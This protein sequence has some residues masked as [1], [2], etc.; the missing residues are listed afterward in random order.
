MPLISLLRG[1]YRITNLLSDEGGFGRTYLAK[2]VDKLK[3]LCVVKQFAPKVQGSWAL[4]KA[5]TLFQEEAKR[6]Q[7]LGEHN[8]IPTLLAYFEQDH[9]MYL[10]QQFI[11]GRNL[12]NELKA[13]GI[14]GETKIR[15]LLVD[16]LPVIKFIHERQVIHRDIKPQNIISPKSNKGLV[17][18]DF[19]ASKQLS[20]TV[21]SKMGTT[22]GSHG[23]SPI[24]QIKNGEA[25]PASDLFSLGATCFHLLTGISPFQLSVDHGFGWV[26]S[27]Q[28]YLKSPVSSELCEILD[29]M[30]KKE[31]VERYQSAD[32]VIK[33]LN[34]KISMPLP[35]TPTQPKISTQPYSSIPQA[36][37]P[38]LLTVIVPLVV[39]VLAALA[40]YSKGSLE[41]FARSVGILPPKTVQSSSTAPAIKPPFRVNELKPGWVMKF[42][43][44]E[45]LNDV[46]F[47]QDSHWEVIPRD[48][49]NPDLAPEDSLV[50]LQLC[51]T[52]TES[53]PS[54][55][56][57]VTT[58]T[59]K[60][61]QLEKLKVE[62]LQS[63][64]GTPCDPDFIPPLGPN[65]PSNP[66]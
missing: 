59:I 40:G 64:T 18:I 17:L 63:K 49:P 57:I 31:I 11:D 43:S 4:Q 9:N 14:Y 52:S 66:L 13:Q 27:W 19:G 47:P 12:L 45:T 61:S 41:E 60:L 1:R 51:S 10:V 36:G 34:Y 44:E 35:A 42:Q 16:L 54:K 30:L 53:L 15:E 32:E 22:I 25:Y 48:E 7:E 26:T 65:K 46:N 24:E 8:Q 37:K 56:T 23:Y 55:V 39:V 28:Q 29:K 33:D 6:L 20:V 5:M 62:V 21:Q 58:V 3:E 50:N 2:D 38:S